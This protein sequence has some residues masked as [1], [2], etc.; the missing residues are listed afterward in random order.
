MAQLINKVFRAKRVNGEDANA[1]F[2]IRKIDNDPI[3]G[4]GKCHRISIEVRESKLL[5]KKD[6]E[7]VLCFTE[8]FTIGTDGETFMQTYAETLYWSDVEKGRGDKEPMV[9]INGKIMP[10]IRQIGVLTLNAGDHQSY[11]LRAA[12]G[13]RRPTNITS[14]YPELFPKKLN[15]SGLFG[16][17][18]R[19]TRKRAK[20]VKRT[21]KSRRLGVRT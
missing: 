5:S 1:E 15:N 8:P 10:E 7:G 3:E 17:G 9:K 2:I 11:Y 6:Y 12:F 21:H 14:T 19:R 13:A 18:G 20:K 4:G 16:T